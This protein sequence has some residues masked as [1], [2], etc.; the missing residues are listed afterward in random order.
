MH[1]IG[2]ST[3]LKYVTGNGAFEIGD[4][5]KSTTKGLLIDGPYCFA[6]IIDRIPEELHDECQN[7]NDNPVIFF[8]DSQG[9]GDQLVQE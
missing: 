5:T 7:I 4:G 9:F 2:K 3:F 1:Q 6:D 8:M